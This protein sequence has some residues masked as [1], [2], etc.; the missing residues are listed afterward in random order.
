VLVEG[1]LE[2]GG[3]GAV[4]EFK[5]LADIE[6]VRNSEV[7]EGGV[8]DEELGGDGVGDVKGE[9]ADFNEIA[10]VFIVVKGTEVAKKEAVGPCF[11]DELEVAIFTGLED[12]WGGEI[13]LR[14]EI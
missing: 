9:V 10:T 7:V 4:E 2:P 3:R 12:A 11:L 8:L 6:I 13:D 14:T 5:D 1:E